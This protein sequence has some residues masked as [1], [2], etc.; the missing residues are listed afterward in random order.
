MTPVRH[1]GPVPPQAPANP[2]TSPYCQP[3]LAQPIPAHPSATQ[4]RP[5]PL[6]I[7]IPSQPSQ[8]QIP[9]P[10]P[11]C[12]PAVCAGHP[13]NT[14]QPLPP[15]TPHLQQYGLVLHDAGVR[16]P[17][18]QAPLQALVPGEVGGW[19]V[20]WGLKKG[21]ISMPRRPQPRLSPRAAACRPPPA[22]GAPGHPARPPRPA[23]APRQPSCRA[24][25]LCAAACGP[26]PPPA[27]LQCW[28]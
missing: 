10:P 12:P 27:H 9:P 5:S 2:C 25:C 7:A 18:V 8:S 23:G 17:L 21:H 4:T 11:R 22:R 14:R 15:Q 3:S 6:G 13:T 20:G 26:W 19:W 1:A 28:K 24:S 16:Q